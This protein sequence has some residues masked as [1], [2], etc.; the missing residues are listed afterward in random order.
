VFVRL[1]AERPTAGAEAPFVPVA[2]RYVR[3]PAQSAAGAAPHRRA[4]RFAAG[5]RN[6]DAG[7]RPRGG[8]GRRLAEDRS[9][10]G[11]SRLRADDDPLAGHRRPSSGAGAGPAAGSGRPPGSRDRDLRFRA[12]GSWPAGRFGGQVLGC[13]GGQSRGADHRV[14]GAER[15]QV[16]GDHVDRHAPCNV[17]GSGRRRRPEGGARGGKVRR[18]FQARQSRRAVGRCAA[19]RQF[20]AVRAQRANSG[21][22]QSAAGWG[23]QATFRR[24]E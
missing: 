9:P 13:G 18:Q 3:R 21:S 8:R 6:P 23:C 2:V 4:A 24:R 10:R 14:A 19:R 17:S 12:P 20:P 7:T 16:A 15:G 11:R 5:D 1:P 22:R